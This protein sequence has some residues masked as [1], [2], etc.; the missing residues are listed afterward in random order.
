MGRH[1]AGAAAASRRCGE[2][3][4]PRPRRLVAA[5]RLTR[6]RRGARVRCP[7][8]GRA[9]MG[10]LLAPAAAVLLALGGCAT[11]G[12]VD[13]LRSDIAGLRSQAE[14]VDAKASRAEAAAQAQAA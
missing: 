2:I 11:K 3:S 7:R 5:S 1:G 10:K 6:E 9:T 13:Q 12:D 8:T 14:T 4:L